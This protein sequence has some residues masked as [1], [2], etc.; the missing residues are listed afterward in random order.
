MWAMVTKEF[1]QLKRDRRT[2][3]MM[4]VLP[5]ILLVVFGY[6]ARFNVDSIS[7][8]V[9][10][11]GASQVASSLKAPFEVVGV[12][13]GGGKSTAESWLQ[14]GR[15]TVGFVTTQ[16]GSRSSSTGRSCSPCRRLRT[17]LHSCRT[18]RQARSA[19]TGRASR[20][21]TTR[22]FRRRGSWSPGWPG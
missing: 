20:F 19:L 17:L 5:V 1:R 9:V 21:S 14:D 7:T 16:A 3:A 18:R 6:A 4:I 22:I 10:G 2:L 12:D 13:A 11:P 8:V 15:A